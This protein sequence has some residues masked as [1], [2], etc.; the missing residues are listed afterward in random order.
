MVGAVVV[1]AETTAAAMAVV[2]IKLAFIATAKFL[3]LKI[4]Y[5]DEVGADVVLTHRI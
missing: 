5:M 3:L 4:N 1:W 2:A